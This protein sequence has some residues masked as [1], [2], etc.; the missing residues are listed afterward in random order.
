MGENDEIVV[1]LADPN[2][3]DRLSLRWLFNYPP[4]SR[5]VSRRFDGEILEPSAG[6]AEVRTR[7]VRFKPICFRDLVGGSD[8]RAMLVVSDRGFEESPSSE[9][10]FDVVPETARVLRLTWNVKKACQ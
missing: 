8:H 1:T 5:L 6:G 3:Q 2:P 7:V 9:F 4:Y 10:P